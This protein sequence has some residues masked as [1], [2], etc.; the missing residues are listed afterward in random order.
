M[1]TPDRHV[2]LQLLERKAAEASSNR[3]ECEAALQEA[4]RTEEAW[5]RLLEAQKEGRFAEVVSIFRKESDVFARLRDKED[6]TVPTLEEFYRESE[7]QAKYTA[8]RFDALFP[9][10]CDEA[11]IQL[12][13][14][15]RHPKYSI[16]EFIQ[17]I[18]DERKL[19]AQITTRDSGSIFLP[20]DIDPIVA[21]LRTEIERLFETRRNPKRFLIGLQKAYQAVLRE[22]KK[23]PGDTL[24]LRRVANRLSKNW[25]RFRYD[26]FN[27]DLGNVVRSGETAIDE[28]RL[29]LDHTR[30][31]R[32][33]M[34]LYGL[35][36]SGYMGFISF[37]PEGS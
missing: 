19:E 17:T 25:A 7:K 20:L 34:L 13:F 2:L 26:E 29:H 15:S 21:H 32:Q 16:Q 33:G 30:D 11:G 22:E 28:V 35:E 36:R 10:A 37:K 23:S 4:Q 14:S 1:S 27:I 8:R 24:P 9:K 18:I 31:T 5:K 12:D 3:R 6:E